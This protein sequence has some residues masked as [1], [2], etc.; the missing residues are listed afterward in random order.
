MLD[1]T[2]F[3]IGS[4]TA[5][6][7]HLEKVLSECGWRCLIAATLLEA[8]SFENSQD[9]RVFFVSAEELGSEPLASWAESLDKSKR[10]VAYSD[11]APDKFSNITE[12]VRLFSLVHMRTTSPGQLDLIASRAFEFSLANETKDADCANALYRELFEASI[13][14][15]NAESLKDLLD[16]VCKDIARSTHYGRALLVLADERFRIQSSHAYYADERDAVPLSHLIGSPLMPILP[17]APLVPLGKGFVQREASAPPNHQRDNRSLILSL[18]KSD[19]TVFGF[20]TLDSASHKVIDISALSEPVSL[21]LKLTASFIEAQ[22]LR[23]ALKSRQDS[24]GAFVAER[25]AELR[26]AQER[27]SRLVN[28]TEDIVYLTDPEG[29]IIYLNNAFTAKLG[30]TRE[31]Y[32]GKVL[33][34]VL[35]NLSAE[36]ELSQATISSIRDRQVGSTH[37]EIELFSKE[38]YRATF[39]ITHQWVKQGEDVIAGQGLLRDLTEQREMRAQLTRSE[40]LGMAGRLASGIAH[41]INNPLQAISSHVE[42]IKNIVPDNEGALKSLNIVADSVDR[43]RLIARSLLDLQRTESSVKQ[44]DSINEIIEK[45]LA[46]L[47]PQLRAADVEVV[48]RLTPELPQSRIN[49]AEIEQVLLNLILNAITAMAGGGELKLTSVAIDN[50]IQIQVADTGKGISPEVLRTLFTP[51]STHREHGGGLGLGLFLSRNIVRDH[52]GE[53][54]VKSPPGQGA[55]FTITLPVAK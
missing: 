33:D 15:Q 38:G 17:N 4:E 6:R 50:A 36:N 1:K 55:E 37:S 34:H 43:I 45:A 26:Q 35:E 14:L 9:V 20:L 25:S 31:N 40:R 48:K 54:T 53:L 52:G 16:K 8:R 22:M 27:F 51:F 12:N 5:N 19:G 3:I 10:I 46:L 24:V 47:T 21:L 28:L 32:I 7:A 49:A 42:G 39:A 29:R 11:Q 13:Q 23:A 44:A 30:F 18:D 41:E 2:L